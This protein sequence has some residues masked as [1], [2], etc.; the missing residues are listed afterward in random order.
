V[1]WRALTTPAIPVVRRYV[2][3]AIFRRGWAYVCAAHNNNDNSIL[4][5]TDKLP[6]KKPS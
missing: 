4:E 5:K 1:E 6:P 3:F 2:I